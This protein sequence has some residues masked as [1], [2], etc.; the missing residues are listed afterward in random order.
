MFESFKRLPTITRSAIISQTFGYAIL[1]SLYL[2]LGTVKVVYKSDGI[3]SDT[4][5]YWEL[6]LYFCAA[7]AYGIILWKHASKHPT[8]GFTE[9]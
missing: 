5:G 2:A 7:L 8:A 1:F 3:S 9:L 4:L 6:S